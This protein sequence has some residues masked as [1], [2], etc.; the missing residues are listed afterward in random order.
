MRK[1]SKKLSAKALRVVD[2]QTP[3]ESL[4][5]PEGP[6]E[7]LVEYGPHRL[8]TDVTSLCHHLREVN[9]DK[10]IP[11]RLCELNREV[12]AELGRCASDLFWRELLLGDSH[13]CTLSTE[14]ME[15]IKV[16]T[17]REVARK[18]SYPQPCCNS[19]ADS[20]NVTPKF[21]K[22]VETLQSHKARANSFRGLIIV[23]SKTVAVLMAKLLEQISAAGQIPSMR[24]T[25]LI[26]LSENGKIPDKSDWDLLVI[27]KSLE[28]M[29]LPDF[30][31]VIRY[32]V[33]ESQLSYAYSYARC[34]KSGG[35]L[36]H[37]M[38]R[39]R[40]DHCRIVGEMRTLGGDVR[41][42][43]LETIRRPKGAIPPRTLHES[44]DPYRLDSDDPAGEQ[45]N[46]IRDPTTSSYIQESDAVTVIH[47]L[48]ASSQSGQS[49]YWVRPLF[50]FQKTG[51]G[52]DA[53]YTCTVLFPAGCPVHDVTGPQR[54]SKWQARRAA[55]FDACR[56][57]ADAGVL[58]YRTFPQPSPVVLSVD[59]QSHAGAMVT[60]NG[61][62]NTKSA[63]ASIATH[64][65]P[66]KS[67][68]FWKNTLGTPPNVLHPMIVSIWP[69]VGGDHAPVLILTREPLPDLAD[70]KLWTFGSTST[71]HLFRA[72]PLHVDSTQLDLLHKYT[73]RVCRALCNKPLSYSVESLPY[74][75]APT[76]LP[77]GQSFTNPPSKRGELASLSG[78]IPW[79]LVE[80]A[81]GQFVIPLVSDK[82]IKIRPQISDT[83]V[84]DRKVEFT[85]RHFVERVR[86]DMTPL[87][88]PSDS[89]RESEFP[90]FLEFCKA[91]IKTFTGLRDEHQPL[92][93][94]SVLPPPMNYLS[95]TFKVMD[96]S[97]HSQVKYLIPELCFRFTISAS[98][99]RTML[100]VPST[101]RRIDDLLLA[102]EFN[103]R[104]FHNIISED[105]LLEAITPPA[106]MVEYDYDRLELFGDGFLKYLSSLYCFTTMP[107]ACEGD[108]HDHRRAMIANKT[109][110]QGV[111]HSGL[112]Q[113]IQSKAFTVKLWQPV[114]TELVESQ[115]QQADATTGDSSTSG[116]QTTQ[117]GRRSKRQKQKEEHGLQWLGE[118][119]LADV[120]EAILGAAYFSGGLSA[121]LRA[122]KILNIRI[123]EVDQWSDLASRGTAIHSDPPSATAA[124]SVQAIEGILG[125]TVKKPQFFTHALTHSAMGIQGPF[126]TERLQFLGDAILD[127]LVVRYIFDRYPSLSP[128]GLSLLKNAMVS[129]SALAALCVNIGLHKHVGHDSPV[130]GNTIRTYSIQLDIKREEEYQLAKSEDRLPGQ[131]WAEFDA[132]KILS[133]IIES[134]I[135]ALYI[136]DD[137]TDTGASTFFDFAFKPFYDRHIRLKTLRLHPSA[138][139]TDLLESFGCKQYAIE[140]QR[141][142]HSRA[143]AEVKV[144]SV[145]LAR[146]EDTTVAAAVRNAALHALN[147][148]DGDPYFMTR[149]CDCRR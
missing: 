88:K 91:R 133:D 21:A 146:A 144:H 25:A 95:P 82:D 72:A 15:A 52:G 6:K 59:E 71:A 23:R 119:T 4:Q 53:F 78:Y 64:Q 84:Q 3:T 99:Y 79:D 134:T 2:S 1:Y 86:D 125:Y 57:L 29:R 22:V 8:T 70:I 112:P 18:W 60:S 55:C 45:V 130:V 67:P 83:I 51:E 121:A 34:Q 37:M 76:N 9:V 46:R 148:L 16:D 131:Y 28:D 122:A 126:H 81:A 33:F 138:T 43:F 145:I 97:K 93:E 47:R 107:S 66:K 61:R 103:A 73:L 17:L 13:S 140:K 92:L 101:M 20:F 105:L 11:E 7:T 89:P 98:T 136:S 147:A 129:N 87:S 62:E 38:E 58:N 132:P 127:F 68:E 19:R 109:L 63:K 54:K 115:S 110:F 80:L 90:S 113:F 44:L 36:I 49:A 26:S 40:S 141:S 56:R 94:V 102:K 128:G 108:L 77:G 31:L 118:K 124:S 5:L 96:A 139:L 50:H 42:W 24:S 69:A 135:G 116:G 120:V 142:G 30:T 149:T 137:F 104:F 143:L 75:L 35:S 74:F 39:N 111:V 123:P 12:Q 100:L 27:P 85:N 106:A 114:L 41:R 65:F 14:E 117:K 32:D 48:A 10:H